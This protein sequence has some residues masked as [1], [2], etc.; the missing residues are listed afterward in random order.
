LWGPSR[1][2]GSSTAANWVS[3]DLNVSCSSCWGYS[4]IN[5]LKLKIICY[6]LFFEAEAMQPRT[7]SIRDRGR[8]LP[9]FVS[10]FDVALS[11][12]VAV[13]SITRGYLALRMLI[14]CTHACICGRR[15]S[16]AAVSASGS[17]PAQWVCACLPCLKFAG[18][19]HKTIALHTHLPP[20]IYT[21]TQTHTHTHIYTHIHTF[22]YKHTHTVA[23]S[24]W[25]LFLSVPSYQS[26]SVHR[27]EP[28]H[29]HP[30]YLEESIPT[31]SQ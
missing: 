2:L 14:A 22:T 11:S 15:S 18:K 21:Y 8:F 6:G 29:W 13:S 25:G 20:H 30:T 26:A 16:T 4:L 23:H 1:H 3:F 24:L 19:F 9:S 10:C 7:Q 17:S 31:S 27:E 12:S 5:T 28:T